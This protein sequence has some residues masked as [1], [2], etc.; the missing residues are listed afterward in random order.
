MSDPIVQNAALTG[1]N[2]LLHAEI[3]RLRTRL[4]EAEALLL[5]AAAWREPIAYCAPDLG[6]AI[7][8]LDACGAF[9]ADTAVQPEAAPTEY[10]SVGRQ[11]KFYSGFGHEVWRN[12]PAS[13]NGSPPVA[14]REIFVRGTSSRQSAATR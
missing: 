9:C 7:M 14:E 1:E 5:R 3:E 2:M 13:Y 10:V 8:A 6:G 12:E 4:V 11:Y